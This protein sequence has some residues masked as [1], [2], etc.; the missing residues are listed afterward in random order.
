M[1][2]KIKIGMVQANNSFANQTYLPY[3]IGF[4]Q[5]Y[6][7][8]HLKNN[9][10]FEFM[11][12]IYKRIPIADA[13]EKLIES[14]MAVFS[15]YVWN[16]NFSSEIAKRLK[17]EKPGIINVFGGCYIP[18][19]N[20]NDF[21]ERNEFI[22]IACIGEGERVFKSI[23]ENYDENRLENKL[24]IPSISYRNKSGQIINNQ[25]GERINNLDEIP[26][27]YLSG[28][29]NKLMEANPEETWVALWETNRG[30]PFGC[31][32]CE[33]GG[34]YHKKL[35]SYD[36]ETILREIDWFSDNKI[37]FIFCC[38]SNFGILK[39]DLD[40]VKRV[41]DNKTK[42]G[43]PKALS[44]QNTKNSTED[45]YL[46][47]KILSG[48]GLNKG[49]NLAF[50]SLNQKTLEI[51]GRK[52]IPTEYF[53]ELQR[54]FT[55]DGIETFSDIILGLPNETYETFTDGISTL[56][57]SGQHNRIQLINLSVLP[58][59]EMG[60][61]K[62][63]EKYG[64]HSVETRI[65]NLHG[66]LAEDEICEKQRL[67][68]GTKSMPPEEWVKTRIFS[69]ATSLL[70]FD[71]LLQI[72]FTIL[73]KEYGIEYK[74]LIEKFVYEKSEKNPILNDINLFFSEKARD[75]QNGGPELCESKKWLNIWWPTDELM[76]I[77]LASKG[78]LEIFYKEAQEKLE[79][80]V[81]T[82]QGK[83]KLDS[84]IIQDSINLNKNLIKLPFNKTNL[85][86]KLN[87]NIW[88][89]YKGHLV[90]KNMPIERGD[91]KYGINR[92]DEQ[93]GSWDEWCQKVVWYGNKKGDYL[94]SCK[95]IP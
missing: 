26:S 44:V 39:R 55:I 91:Y 37:E 35:Y 49:V 65:V 7:Q 86:I 33:W 22:D 32:Y 23:L 85:T 31:S 1:T 41:A 14:D 28:V 95:L 53:E 24:N 61:S 38:D 12:P 5:A 66:S 42:Y 80:L 46:V 52:N 57:K 50:Q 81:K 78:N 25:H 56:I 71:K 48:A 19:R 43:Y 40:I 34:D 84:L 30:C 15:T 27:P 88:E 10:N 70:Y 18:G 20:V 13:V 87:N 94:Y 74:D 77:D 62:Y 2:N 11:L 47:Q 36:L 6:A 4:L 16:F 72:P 63:Q 68:V 45:S 58:N 73:N 79:D 67:V 60:D 59:S 75:I 51:I 93:W 54:K 17:K 76:F 89:T 9:E 69:W 29:F 21:L 64:M 82:S 3:S 8:K 90:G 92:T 83:Q